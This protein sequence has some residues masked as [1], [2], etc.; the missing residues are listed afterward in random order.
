MKPFPTTKQKGSFDHAL[1]FAGIFILLLVAIISTVRQAVQPSSF[2]L[3]TPD[4]EFDENVQHSLAQY[5]PWYASGEYIN[6]PR[7]CEVD[8]V[9]IVSL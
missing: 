3:T 6:P 7:G 2:Q 8:Q 4:L 1:F 5:A 9:N